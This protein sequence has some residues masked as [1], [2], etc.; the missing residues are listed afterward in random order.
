MF[1]RP[2]KA[3][4]SIASRFHGTIRRIYFLDREGNAFEIAKEENTASGHLFRR[5]TLQP[6]THAS[7]LC[8]FWLVLPQ[9]GERLSHLE[10]QRSSTRDAV[11]QTPDIGI[12]EVRIEV[13]CALVDC[14]VG[15]HG[16]GLCRTL[17]LA[18][19]KGNRTNHNDRFCLHVN[20]AII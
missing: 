2:R 5:P 15:F 14:T 9:V 4:S 11:K 3:V 17:P 10:N 13:N 19:V 6:F 18:K 7:H 8:R 16:V 20:K 1:I 12:A